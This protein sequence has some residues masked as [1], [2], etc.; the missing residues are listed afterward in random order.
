MLVTRS[1]C[2]VHNQQLSYDGMMSLASRPQQ[3]H[4]Y[5]IAN[6]FQSVRQWTAWFARW[7]IVLLG[8]DLNIETMRQEYQRPG[9]QLD[10]LP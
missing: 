3:M 7:F 9:S 4:V 2:G 6:A 1:P 5:I 10:V 8:Y